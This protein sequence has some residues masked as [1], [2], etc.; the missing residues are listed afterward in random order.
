MQPKNR[1]QIDWGAWHLSP[2][3]AVL[4]L[5]L[6]LYAGAG[7]V[8]WT[9]VPSW[10]VAVIG[11][12][13]TAALVFVL[14]F[15]PDLPNNVLGYLG[16]VGT[17]ASGWLAYVAHAGLDA[18]GVLP[19]FF[20]AVGLL[21][22]WAWWVRATV[23]RHRK[24]V[25]AA[26]VVIAPAGPGGDAE[27]SRI[28]TETGTRGVTV[29]ARTGD[30]YGGYAVPVTLPSNGSVTWQTLAGMLPQFRTAARLPNDWSLNVTEGEH[31]GEAVIRVTSSTAINKTYPIPEEHHPLTIRRPVDLGRYGNGE[32]TRVL[33]REVSVR[34]VGPTRKGKTNLLHVFISEIGRCT[35]AM[36]WFI[37]LAKEGKVSA[38]W[39]EPFTAGRTP[40]PVIDWAATTPAQARVMLDAFIAEMRYRSRVFKDAE[41]VEPT[42]EVPALFL[43]VDEGTDTQ[44]G[45]LTA[46]IDE[47]AR[48]GL[49]QA[50]SII[51]ASH[52]PVAAHGSTDLQSQSGITIGLPG[53]EIDRLFGWDKSYN[54][55]SLTC[56]GSIYIH[57]EGGD[58][59]RVAKVHRV[60][61]EVIPRF[62]EARTPYRPR[63][64]DLP[65]GG[66]VTAAELARAFAE[67]WNDARLAEAYA[68]RYDARTLARASASGGGPSGSDQGERPRPLSQAEAL[69]K[70]NETLERA[71]RAAARGGSDPAA[72]RELQE[73]EAMLNATPDELPEPLVDALAVLQRL[74][75]TQLTT[76]RLLFELD[77]DGLTALRLSK[78]LAPF[79]VRPEDLGRQPDGTRPRGYFRAHLQTAKARILGRD[80]TPPADAYRW[81]VWAA[82]TGDESAPDAP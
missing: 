35:D 56:P 77:R 58:A 80:L 8:Q 31:G 45:D 40:R 4:S 46:K 15:L 50:C 66:V 75:V 24:A 59:G 74:D 65:A 6:G 78:A 30:P 32:P 70:Y 10:Q 63:L 42:P 7:I 18:P 73:L 5:G 1:P 19:A 62:A 71:R 20:I 52:R 51:F 13:I 16:T 57:T 53:K 37:D 79:E 14:N 72:L 76:E 27:W 54:P 81:P 68:N 11:V 23:R 44:V 2:L 33:L 17:A 43:V 67:R 41:K 25:E 9:G 39:N 29:G 12:S 3:S 21:G 34:I 82:G 28:L 55:K 48:K 22:P 36:V 69:A 64:D 38:R 60:E 49:E 26:P 61:W 47:I